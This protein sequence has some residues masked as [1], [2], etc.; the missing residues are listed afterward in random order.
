M[1]NLAEAQA[2]LAGTVIHYQLATPQLINLIEQ[3]L[4][5]GTLMSFE[6]GTCY[7]DSDTFHSPL[8]TFDVPANIGAQIDANTQAAQLQSNQIAVTAKKVRDHEE[9]IVDIETPDTLSHTQ[10]SSIAS[11]PVGALEGAVDNF[12]SKGLSLVNSVVNGDFSDG[13]TGWSLQNASLSTEQSLFGSNSIK[14][15]ATGAMT[16]NIKTLRQEQEIK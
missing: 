5:D 10:T 12:E 11:L 13:T 3:G 16:R 2:D 7:L 6:N 1:S 4:T 15:V 14:H 9:R 8:V